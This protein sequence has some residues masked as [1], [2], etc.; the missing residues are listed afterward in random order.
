MKFRKVVVK[1][2]TLKEYRPE[3]VKKDLDEMFWCTRYGH[4]TC[5][6]ACTWRFHKRNELGFDQCYNCPIRKASFRELR[7]PRLVVR[8]P[9]DAEGNITD[10]CIVENPGDHD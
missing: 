7:V 1:S 9:R 2:V 8:F 4:Y 3:L 10:V 6:H 5:M